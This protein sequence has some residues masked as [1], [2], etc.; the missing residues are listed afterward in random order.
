[1]AKKTLASLG[2][3]VKT[4]RG[5]KGLREIAKDIDVGPATLMRVE[6]GH[7]PD[8]GTFAK[9]CKWLNEDPNEFLG[10]KPSGTDTKQGIV[11]HLKAN[12]TLKK[13][14]VNALSKM[15]LLAVSMQPEPQ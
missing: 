5:E 2:M 1:M 7:I 14:T 4:K 10:L 9:V 11:A 13:E 12:R 15:I 3:M 6:N 8:I